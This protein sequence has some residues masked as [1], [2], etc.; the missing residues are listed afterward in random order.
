[1]TDKNKKAPP[2][3]WRLVWQV[4]RVLMIAAITIPLFCGALAFGFIQYLYHAPNH[5]SI[6]LIDTKEVQFDGDV[7]RQRVKVRKEFYG[8]VSYSIWQNE[9]TIHTNLD[10]RSVFD[11]LIKSNDLTAESNGWYSAENCH[12]TLDENGIW[13]SG[14]Y[15]WYSYTHPES[16]AGETFFV[17]IAL[18]RDN[19]KIVRS[20]YIAVV[21][22]PRLLYFSTNLSDY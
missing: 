1:M 12:Y 14:R 13:Q 8:D 11:Y 15:E 7:N 9:G 16:P 22:P 5:H 21:S 19:E 3:R 6:D 10:N 17:C 20:Y 2:S 18:E 4:I